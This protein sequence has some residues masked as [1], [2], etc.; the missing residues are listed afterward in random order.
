MAVNNRTFDP[1]EQRKVLEFSNKVAMTS[2]ETG[3]L[4]YV[5]YP[6]LL[7]G[8]QMACF[9][10][11][12]DA[13]LMLT[14]SRFIVGTGVTT[15]VLG[16]TFTPPSFGTSGVIPSGVSLPAAGSTLN[17]LMPNDILGYQVGGTGG[18]AAI[19]GMAGCF[20]VKP[21]QDVKV[22]LGSI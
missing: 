15:W 11:T 1:S 5:P 19:N 16:S 17:V 20:V 14:V 10:I 9:S 8:S 7:Q 21:L 2:G 22:Y 4:N 13:Y 18:T 12:A 6:C 3:V